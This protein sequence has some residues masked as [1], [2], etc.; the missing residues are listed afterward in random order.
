MSTFTDLQRRILEVLYASTVRGESLDLATLCHRVEPSSEALIDKALYAFRSR[1][2]VD[3][4]E[5]IGDNGLGDIELTALG[6]EQ[7]EVTRG[8]GQAG[9][10]PP[11]RIVIQAGNVQIGDHNE[12]KIRGN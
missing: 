4:T 9:A 11:Q 8:G 3:F 5:Y 10:Q 12:Q 1:G 6:L 2:L 7:V